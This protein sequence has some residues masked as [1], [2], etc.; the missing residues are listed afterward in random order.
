MNLISLIDVD[1]ILRSL[2][3][4]QHSKGLSIAFATLV[5]SGCAGY[6]AF[7]QGQ[8]DIASGKT[9]PG[10]AQLKTAMEQAPSNNEY[11]RSYFVQRENAVNTA[12]REAEVS[13]ERGEFNAAQ[14]AFARA[15]RLDTANARANGGSARVEAARRH[16]V[17]I[18][19]AA[20]LARE[21]QLDVAIS[22]TRQVLAES[23]THRRARQALRQLMRQQAEATGKELGIYPKLKAAFQ[24]PV[25][26]SFN[27]ARLLQVFE[28]LKQASGLNYML[29]RD[30]KPDMRVTLSVTNKPVED[31]LR[32]LLATNQLESRVLDGDTLLIYPNT[33]AKNT[34]YREMVVRSFYLRNADA[35]EVAVMLKTVAKV[36]DVVVDKKLNMVMVRDSAETIRLAEKVIAAQDLAEPEVMLELEVLEV[37]MSRLVDLGIRWPDSI[38]AG[39][40]GEE[41]VAGQLR[42]DETRGIVDSMVRL[43]FSNP[44]ISA[45]LRSQKGNANLLANPR[46]RVRNKQ[47]AKILIG[48][49]VPVITT[50]ASANVG[51]F[52]TVTYLDVGLKLEIEPVVSLDDEVSMKIALEVSNILESIPRASGTLVYRLGTRNTSTTLR[53]RDGETNILAG[54]IQSD[55]RRA[56]NGVPG[57]NEIPLVSKLFGVSQDSDTR[58]EIVLLI[59]PRIV[60]NLDLPG[61]GLQEF[62]AGTESSVGAAPI[63]LGIPRPA[64]GNVNIPSSAPPIPPLLAPPT[65]PTFRPLLPP[66][67]PSPGLVAP[68]L[69]PSSPG[70]A[71]EPIGAQK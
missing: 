25:S 35:T 46:V 33:P 38:S 54:L 16:W 60:R 13:L 11:R 53:V 43:N 41:E 23:P 56:N 9:E 22:K 29:E 62:L 67:T 42:L 39:I 21:N 70:D 55:E 64:E 14:E 32:L 65:I 61:L 10:V 15:L 45:Q 30:V 58:T 12:L 6:Q 5:L 28:A 34:E 59:T 71:T 18:E 50:T 7:K 26:L 44:L 49:R 37:N 57:L 36:K 1:S 66:A 20:K 40:V 24:V 63:Q 8:A 4:K 68:P 19:Q 2:H 48:E 47:P 27:E 31:I 3:L 52:E 69:V 51:S 17:A